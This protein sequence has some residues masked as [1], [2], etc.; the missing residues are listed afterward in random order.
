M[1]LDFITLQGEAHSWRVREADR[2]VYARPGPLAQR[3]VHRCAPFCSLGVAALG[4][5]GTTN[6]NKMR[7]VPASGERIER[8]GAQRGQGDSL[9]VGV[10]VE[11]AARAVQDQ[12][13]AASQH[14]RGGRAGGESPLVTLCWACS[15]RP[16]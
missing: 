11:V 5:L 15:S 13:H 9:Q 8:K 1:R 12:A 3:A 10:S 16:Y 7:T 4:M 6:T 2:A 14:C